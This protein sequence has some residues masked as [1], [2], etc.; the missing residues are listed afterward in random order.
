LL[1]IGYFQLLLVSGRRWPEAVA[2]L[3]G[4]FWL[5][6]SLVAAATAWDLYGAIIATA[7]AWLVRGVILI[8]WGELHGAR[9]RRAGALMPVLPPKNDGLDVRLISRWVFFPRSS[10]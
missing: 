10:E 6:I 7:S 5:V 2:N 3:A 9:E 4:A 8:T 1:P